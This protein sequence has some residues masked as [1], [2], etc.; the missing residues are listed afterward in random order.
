L[1]RM[2]SLADIVPKKKEEEE[3]KESYQASLKK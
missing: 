1:T 3:V 2:L